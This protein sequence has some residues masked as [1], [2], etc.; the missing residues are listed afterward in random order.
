MMLLKF[1]VWEVK[2]I[3]HYRGEFSVFKIKKI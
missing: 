1:I 3:K 2:P